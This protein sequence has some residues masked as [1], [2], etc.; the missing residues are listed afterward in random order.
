MPIGVFS[1][2]PLTDLKFRTANSMMRDPRDVIEDAGK[3]SRAEKL[4]QLSDFRRAPLK[5]SRLNKDIKMRT[6]KNFRG[7]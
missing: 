2:A 7:E 5:A 4:Q 3:V 1:N 6:L